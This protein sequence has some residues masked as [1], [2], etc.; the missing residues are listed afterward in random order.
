VM[1]SDSAT[2]QQLPTVDG[3]LRTSSIWNSANKIVNLRKTWPIGAMTFG[4]AT[5]DGRSIATHCKE[6]RAALS[7][8]EDTEAAVTY[9]AYTVEEIARRLQEHFQALYDEEPGGLLGFL[10]GGFSA[11]ERS[12]EMWQVLIAADGHEVSQ[13]MPP[14]EAGIFHQ[15]VTDAISRLVDGAGQDLGA[16][17]IRL[18]VP[19]EQSEPAAE[20]VRSLLSVPWAW[21]GMPLGETIDLARFLVDTTINFVRFTPG[22][23]TVGG[24]IEIAALTKHEGFKWIQRKH[25]YRPELNPREDLR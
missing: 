12:P 23:A 2:T 19:A 20:E 14:G 13:L 11:A 4:R 9:D 10:V 5:L 21:S 22:D 6:L 16:A 8:D 24:P 18:G 25:F 3:D 1:A 17:L 15:G 7:G